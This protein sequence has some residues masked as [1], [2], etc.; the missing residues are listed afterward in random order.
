[1]QI[2][3]LD[4]RGPVTAVIRSIGARHPGA[5]DLVTDGLYLDLR[6]ALRNPADDPAM[7][8]LTG[9][10]TKVYAHVLATSGAR[11]LITRTAVQLRTLADEVPWGRLVRLTV[12]CQ[13]GRHRSVAVAEAVAR[14]AWAAWGGECGV[15]V[16]H[17]HIDH[18]VLPASD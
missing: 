1:M 15:E 10:D 16:E 8:Y 9:L 5:H 17:H 13:G 18:P 6:H 4:G 2:T 3:H 12:A 11:E 7:R 14:R